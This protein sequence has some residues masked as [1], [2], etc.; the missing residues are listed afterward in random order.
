[1]GGNPD[2]GGPPIGAMAWPGLYYI[3]RQE[4]VPG[5]VVHEWDSVVV[6]V[7]KHG[8][9]PDREPAVRRPSPPTD[10][11]HATVEQESHVVLTDD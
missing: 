6:E 1:M 8:D 2:P 10:A 11:A 5:T 4:P 7:V 3:T 9:S